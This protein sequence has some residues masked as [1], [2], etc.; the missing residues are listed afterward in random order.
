MTITR[1]GRSTRGRRGT[2]PSGDDREV[3]ILETAER[4]LE[5]RPLA[6]ISV[7]DLAKGAGISR[8]TFY[9]Y[10]PSKDAVLLTLLERVIAEAD[11]ALDELIRNPPRERNE[12]WRAGIDVFY[13]TFRAHRALVGP[14]AAARYTNPEVRELWSAF[15]QRSIDHT[16]NV[17]AALRERGD[18][19]DNMP[20]H[21]LSTSLNL[22]NEAV[23]TASFAG[24]R[25]AVP[26]ERVLDNLVHIW[27]NAVYGDAP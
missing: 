20:A 7:D 19:P 14:A 16:T 25:P 4:L 5:Q 9:F 8:P 3:A 11:V 12:F 1:N 13:S 2:R 6:E 23:M 17:I 26:D 27:M 22:L 10:F 24:Q 18:L 15:M 21:E